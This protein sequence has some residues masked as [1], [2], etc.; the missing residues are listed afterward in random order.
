MFE[1]VQKSKIYTSFVGEMHTH[2]CWIISGLF[3]ITFG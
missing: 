1:N 3:R 2:V